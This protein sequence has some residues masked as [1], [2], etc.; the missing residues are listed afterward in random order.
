MHIFLDETG[1]TGFKFKR[2]SSTHFIIGYI[3]IN[4]EDLT[5]IDEILPEIRRK[6]G[7]PLDYEFK[8]PF[9][10]TFYSTCFIMSSI[11]QV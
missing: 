10:D 4:D 11:C 2:G 7:L 9:I 6:N 5:C 8:Y 3:V 1:D